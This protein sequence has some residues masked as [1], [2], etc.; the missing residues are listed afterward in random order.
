MTTT[1]NN[2]Y[3]VKVS[4]QGEGGQNYLKFCPRVLYTAPC[5]KYVSIS[6]NIQLLKTEILPETA[7]DELQK[8]MGT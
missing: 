3:Y 8:L 1:L 5:N 2:S 4:T 7:I 6:K